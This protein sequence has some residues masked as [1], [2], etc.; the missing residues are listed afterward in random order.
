MKIR[1]VGVDRHGDARVAF[2]NLVKAPK[3]FPS[4]KLKFQKHT[5][6]KG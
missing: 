1:L 6:K 3:N 2:R 4:L 5:P